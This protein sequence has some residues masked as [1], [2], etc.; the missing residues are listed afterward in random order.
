MGN[1]T[2]FKIEDYADKAPVTS[3]PLLDVSRG[4]DP[5][6]QDFKDVFD[7]IVS[8]GRFIG[9]PHCHALE[10]SVAEICDA[11]HGVGCASGSDALLL[12]LMAVG[13]GPGDEVICPSFTFFRNGQR[14]RSL[15][16]HSRF[17]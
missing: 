15:G 7:E 6:K 9:G 12:A 5:L 14:D 10:Q 16:R 8:S 4:N 3:V 1:P 17:R 13:V 2:S 11:K